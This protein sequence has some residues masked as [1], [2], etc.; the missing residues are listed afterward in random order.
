MASWLQSS[1][2]KWGV[3]GVGRTHELDVTRSTVYRR[4][5]GEQD[6]QSE[7]S[8]GVLDQEAALEA[9]RLC[10]EGLNQQNTA[11]NSLIGCIDVP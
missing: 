9:V 2:A 7:M 1:L 6:T 10:E 4:V 8:N 11:V 3:N 5:R